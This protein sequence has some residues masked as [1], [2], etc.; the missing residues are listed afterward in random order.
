MKKTLKEWL[1][2]NTKT[3]RTTWVKSSELKA[4]FGAFISKPIS[5]TAFRRTMLELGYEPRATADGRCFW[6]LE[7]AEIQRK[8]SPPPTTEAKLPLHLLPH[9]ALCDVARVLDHGRQ[10][11]GERSWEL[12]PEKYTYAMHWA[13]LLR[14]GFAWWRGESTDSVSGLPHLAHLATRAL[15]LLALVQRSAGK[16]DRPITESAPKI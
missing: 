14:H 13:S 2:K 7:I 3:D 4:A 1:D 11:Y 8:F 10:I 16:D 9:D 5:R 6:P 15:F 12:Q